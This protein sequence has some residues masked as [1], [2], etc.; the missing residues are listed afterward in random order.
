MKR[1]NIYDFILRSFTG[2]DPIRKGIFDPGTID[3]YHYATDAYSVV[4]FKSEL[5]EL[6]Y[7]NDKFPAAD[8]VFKD[9]AP[10]SSL[11]FEISDLLENLLECELQFQKSWIPCKKCGGSGDIICA[12]CDGESECK[13]CHGDGL[14]P[15]NEPFAK[16]ELT[17]EDVIMFNIK[18]AP[19]F[20]YRVV[21]TAMLLK[22]EVVTVHYSVTKFQL[23]FDIHD[24]E[25]LVMGK[26]H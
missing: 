13:S 8:S 22:K 15:K 10:E 16:L 9:F 12:C 17:G 7:D 20:L 6:S 25:I 3:G 26:T 2:S 23:M 4:R 18:V 5:S 11:I 19:R 14:N 24:C 1:A 21:N